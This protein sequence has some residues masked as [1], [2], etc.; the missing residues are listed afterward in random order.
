[1][2]ETMPTTRLRLHRTVV[3]VGMMGAGKSAIGRALAAKLGVPLKDSDAVI[4]ERARMSIA[5][6]FDRDGEPFF[7]EKEGQ[8]IRSL[9]DGPPC[10]LS[11]GGGA[12]L[13]AANRD[14]IGRK[15]AVVWLNA[16]LDL[17]WDRVKHRDTRPLL[18]TDNP[19]QTLAEIYDARISAYAK[20]EFSLKVER[21]WSIAQTTN[22]VIGVLKAA[23]VVGAGPA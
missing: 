8:V 22:A 19:R 13:S 9:L 11:T 1:M 4:V 17:L 6:I 12:W 20:A 16:D 23:G 15:A 2:G 14:V 3:L 5:E 21:S 10:I 18:K 7:R